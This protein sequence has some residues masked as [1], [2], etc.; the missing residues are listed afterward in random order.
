MQRQNA[1]VRP[2]TF[3]EQLGQYPRGNAAASGS[4]DAART[5]RPQRVGLV[6]RA[7]PGRDGDDRPTRRRTGLRLLPALG[8]VG[9]HCRSG[10][11]AGR[12]HGPPRRHPQPPSARRPAHEA[13]GTTTVSRQLN[14]LLFGM[15]ALWAVA[16]Y[17]AYR[18]GGPTMFHY[19]LA[20]LGLTLAPAMAAAA[21]R[22]W[23][24]GRSPEQQ[25]L[26]VL[27][28]AGLRMAVALGAGLGLY[29]GVPYFQ[30]AGFWVWLLVFY[31][32]TLALEV[33]LVV[34]RSEP[35]VGP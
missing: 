22:E 34:S 4:I 6:L 10:A 16:A 11:W 31:L 30:G 28:G 24:F 32:A 13:A 9:R 21:W 20:G 15:L 8:A 7:V 2:L 25:L 26:G 19:S 1:A 27:G 35:R 5:S 12:R 29:L 14:H 23:A 18:F 33:V 17:P 3:P